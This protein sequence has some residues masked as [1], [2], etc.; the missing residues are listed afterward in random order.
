MREIRI[1][2]WLHDVVEDTPTLLEDVESAF[3]KSVA[4]LVDCLT[5]VSKPSDGN[6][7]VRK[8]IDR[9]HLAKASSTVSNASWNFLNSINV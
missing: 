3:G 9:Q 5:D 4:Y 1:A 6:R 2:A 7:A 8:E